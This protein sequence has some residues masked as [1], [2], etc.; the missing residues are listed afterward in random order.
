MKHAF[1]D[2]KDFME[3]RA[4][5]LLQMMLDIFLTCIVLHNLCIVSKDKFNLNWVINAKRDVLKRIGY[6][7]KGWTSFGRQK[8]FCY[9]GKSRIHK[10]TAFNN[11]NSQI[12]NDIFKIKTL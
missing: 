9:K 12:Y 11:D 8:N 1:W 10:S 7:S 4:D 5:I 2:F 6:N 3:K